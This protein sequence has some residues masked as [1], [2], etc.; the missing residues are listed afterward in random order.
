MEDR[1][2]FM[3]MVFF[4]FIMPVM[5]FF[6]PLAMATVFTL[7]SL[8]P[9]VRFIK[10]GKLGSIWGSSDLNKLIVIFLAYGL[11]SS[12]WAI[13]PNEAIALWVRIL[14]IFL[15]SLGLF[16]Y[17][18][19]INNKETIMQALLAGIL[20]AL[21][22][23]NI[24]IFTDGWISRALGLSYKYSHEF[25]IVIFNRAA[26]VLSLLSWAAIYYLISLRKI[27]F[28][29]AFFSMVLLTITRLD[30]LSAVIGFF[31]GGTLVFPSV[32]Y[33]GQKALKIFAILAVIGVFSFAALASIINAHQLVGNVPVVP[34]AASDIRL[35]I[36]DYSAKQALKKPIFGWGLNASRSYPVLESEYV[37]GGRSPLPLHPHNNTLQ[38]WLELGVFGMILFA[39]FLW[40]ILI[41]IAKTI[42]DTYMMASCAALFANYFLIG[43]TGYGIWQGWFLGSGILAAIFLKI[44]ITRKVDSGY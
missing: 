16:A 20:L 35:Y 38:I 27:R 30:S 15:C 22:F 33:K 44:A 12:F 6:S 32:Y 4:A 41:N 11:L 19:N 10:Q 14:G 34:G 29:I 9:V 37:Q 36:W 23:A 21:M 42:P 8:Y 28:A 43:Q 25:N 31:I 13:I 26:S 24:E 1:I 7:L 2:Q 5:A 3:G 39:A 40:L 18:P 17:V